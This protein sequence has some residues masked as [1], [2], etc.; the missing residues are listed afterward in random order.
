MKRWASLLVTALFALTGDLKAEDSLQKQIEDLKA[1]IKYIKDN[2]ERSEPVEIVKPVT[3]YVSPAGELFT[4]PQAGGVSPTDG[5]K[6][7]ERRSY[8][9]IKFNRRESV[10]DKIDA[11]VRAAIDGHVTVGMELVGIYQNTIGAGEVIDGTG[12]TRSANRGWGGGGVNVNFSGKPMRNTLI[13]V[14]FDAASGAVGLG[15]AWVSVQGPKKVL[16]L[17]AGII[18]LG[19]TFDANKAAND[20]VS[21]FIHGDFVNN[22]LLLNP[23]N[24][25]GAVVRVD[26]TRYH[27]AV[28]A[29]DSLGASAD[30]FDNL[31][32]IGEAGMLYNLL[33]D[34]HARVWA[35]QLPRG[36]QQPDQALGISWDHRLTTRLTAFARYGKSSYVESFTPEDT[37]NAIPESP[38]VALNTIDWTASGGLE[39]GYLL[40][41]RLRDKVGLAYGR[42]DMQGFVS[43]QFTEIYYKASITPGFSVSLLGQGIHSR[44]VAM[45]PAEALDPNGIDPNTGNPG[46]PT[47]NDALPNAWTV[48]I[49]TQLSY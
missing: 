44:T 36:P 47:L 38:R 27:F 18:D 11:A 17:Q 26:F 49:R 6:L 3:E 7:E 10:N 9:K 5:S 4:E 16:S 40:K 43:E 21:Q 28:G 20:E 14:D 24:F 25:P 39:I 32:W 1:E 33:G 22:A 19:G 31:Y 12:T 13:F 34:G 37:A 42:T 2:Y 35:R 48:G 45:S 46:I 41:K 8:R 30:L 23:G 29:Q 15:E